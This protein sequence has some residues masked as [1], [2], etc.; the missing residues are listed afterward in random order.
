MSGTHQW[1][2]SVV[3]QI[4]PR[5]FYSKHNR[6]TGDL[7]G[8]IAK[9]DYLQWL[10]VDYLWL[11]PVYPS[12]QCDNGYDVSNYCDIDPAFGT[13]DEFRELVAQAG[14][15]G[16]R[17]MMDIVVNHTSTEHPWFQAARASRDNRY[18]DFYIWRDKPNRWQSKF[19]G[20][21]WEL[22]EA[23]GQYYLHLFDKGQA[24]LNWENPC[25]RKAVVEIVRF[26]RDLGVKGFRFDVINLISKC[27]LMSDDDSDGRA[28]YTDGPRVHEYLRQIYQEVFAGTDLISVGEMSSTTLQHC[29]DYTHP[30][31]QELSMAFSFLHMK[32]DYPNGQKWVKAAPDFIELKR[33]MGEWQ[34]GMHAGNGWNALFW[35]NHDQPRIVSRFG[36]DGRYRVESAKMLATALHCLQ[37]TP[38]VYQGEEIGM[39]NPH[40]ETIE[41]YR[42]IETHN[43]YQRLLAEGLAPSQA[44]AVIS[45][46]SRDNSRT[47]MQWDGSPHAGFSTHAPWIDLCRDYR[48]VN[49]AS[50]RRD[51]DSVLHHYRKL[52]ALRKTLPLLVNGAYQDLLPAHPQLWAYLRYDAESAL[53]VLNNL[54]DEASE[55]LLP[56]GANELLPQGR[57]HEARLIIANYLDREHEHGREKN[58]GFHRVLLRPYESLALHFT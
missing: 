50:A 49:V 52:I 44:L 20:S 19:G 47:P 42:D 2:N 34:N 10:G 58:A 14:R 51:P 31:R 38:Y 28:F 4:Y 36:D 46:K 3:Y 33:V 53:L 1:K 48:E 35:C 24:D 30:E 22:D 55:F 54:S 15:R 41:Q 23:S 8:I 13:L 25:V 32:V 16:I 9:L 17:I 45:Q 27:P 7:A 43:A 26:W 39:G 40:F 18:R 5:S 37:G 57:P 6:A 11:C 56:D 29:L 12:P 21:A